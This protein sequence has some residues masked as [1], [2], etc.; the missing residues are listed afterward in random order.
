MKRF[1]SIALLLVFL[2]NMVG[3]YIYFSFLRK[4][5]QYEIKQ[6][7]RNGLK[8]KDLTLIIV[9]VGE[10]SRLNWLKPQKEFSRNGEMFDVVKSTTKEGKTYLYCIN[11]RKEK[12]LI[13]NFRR[14]RQ[15]NKST[16][17]LKKITPVQFLIY[18]DSFFQEFFSD[19]LIYS[20]F[21]NTYS[22]IYKEILD[23]PPNFFTSITFFSIIS[24]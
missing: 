10:L 5:I 9:P 18:K 15:S 14:N 23:P 17:L 16:E 2:F 13:S 11:D 8:E 3:S 19:D 6:I 4:N 20:S 24:I 22:S 21:S 7:I 12:E 1:F